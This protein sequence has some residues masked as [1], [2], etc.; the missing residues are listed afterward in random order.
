M[1]NDI[2]NYATGEPVTTIAFYY[3]KLVKEDELKHV[4]RLNYLCASL[5][6]ERGVSCKVTDKTAVC[7]IFQEIADTSSIPFQEVFDLWNKDRLLLHTKKRR[8]RYLAV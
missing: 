6:G 8:T 5:Y 2:I 3:D 1:R 7:N 4:N